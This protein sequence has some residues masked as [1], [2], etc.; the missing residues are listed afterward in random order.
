MIAMTTR[1][2]ISVNAFL[3]SEKTI[4]QANNPG[5]VAND[6]LKKSNACNRSRIAE[7]N[8]P[9]TCPSMIRWS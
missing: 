6:Y 8:F 7:R 4:Y 3:M 9:A 1:S 5:S 2:S